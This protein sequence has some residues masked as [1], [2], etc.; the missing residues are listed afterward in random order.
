[1]GW[2]SAGTG[3]GVTARFGN[4]RGWEGVGGGSEERGQYLKRTVQT[5]NCRVGK[6]GREAGK[7]CSRS[8]AASG[9]VVGTVN[10]QQQ[11]AESRV[12]VIAP[13]VASYTCSSDVL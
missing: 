8:S 9:A 1:M 11:R 7:T 3:R 10:T 13:C 12:S 5:Y 2:V 6:G 4:L